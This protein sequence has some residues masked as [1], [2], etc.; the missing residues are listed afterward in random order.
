MR[1]ITVVF[2]NKFSSNTGDTIIEVMFAT[3][4]ASLIIVLSIAVMNRG[5]ATTQMAVEHTLVRQ[6]IDSQTEALRF[7]R[8]NKGATGLSS[9]AAAWI[10]ATKAARL[11]NNATPFNPSSCDSLPSGA[12]YIDT[13]TTG[14]G[15]IKNYSNN[16]VETFAIPG[17]GIWVEAVSPLSAN[18]VDF[19]VRACWEPPFSGP[20]ATLGTIVR[21]TK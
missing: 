9:T 11:K 14:A 20:N 15:M 18:Y 1:G 4:V 3:A 7:I 12:F 21:F 10:E 8:D 16:N 2:K 6:G 13:L 17:N 5:V 19:H